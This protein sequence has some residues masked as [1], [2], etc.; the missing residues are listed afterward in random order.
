METPHPD[1]EPKLMTQPLTIHICRRKGLFPFDWHEL[2]RYKD[3]ILLLLYRDFASRFKQTILGPAWFVIQP[4]LTTLVFT[5]IFGRVAGMSTDATPPV[6]FYLAGLLVWNYHANVL[7]A[8]GNSFQTNAHLYGK[9]YFPRIIV[10]F[11][12][13]ISQL[14]GWFIQMVTFLVFFLYYLWFTE[15]G[16][17]LQ[18]GW[19]MLATPLLILQAGMIGLGAGLWLSA[20]TAKYRDLQHAQGFLVQTWLYISPVVYPLSAIP[21]KWQWLAAINPMTMVIEGVKGC[22]LG[23]SSFDAGLYAIS[24]VATLLLFGSGLILFGKVER[25]FV[26]SV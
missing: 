3:L 12:A 25:T 17:T 16:D 13:T 14:M 19:E 1:I 21:E 6:L 22:L 20:A 8:T 15:F 5:V 10:P 23:V 18:P 2:V 24:V 4:L 26:D 9:V 11:A 7:Q